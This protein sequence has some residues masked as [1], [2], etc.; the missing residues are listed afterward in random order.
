MDF[1]PSK[2]L[3]ARARA[4]VRSWARFYVRITMMHWKSYAKQE[5]TAIT[6]P[7]DGDSPVWT[8]ST[9]VEVLYKRAS[10]FERRQHSIARSVSSGR[11]FAC[12]CAFICEEKLVSWAQSWFWEKCFSFLSVSVWKFIL[13]RLL[14][15]S[16]GSGACIVFIRCCLWQIRPIAASELMN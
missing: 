5:H 4:C 12:S 13:W 2:P 16:L 6:L 14:N 1:A 15:E 7:R 9:T 10:S 11:L 3:H 8:N